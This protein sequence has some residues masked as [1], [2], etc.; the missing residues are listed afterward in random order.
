MQLNLFSYKK[1][2]SEQFSTEHSH[3]AKSKSTSNS[4]RPSQTLLIV[5]ML[6]HLIFPDVDMERRHINTNLRNHGELYDIL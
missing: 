6:F 1:L 4:K 3:S 5:I 2:T